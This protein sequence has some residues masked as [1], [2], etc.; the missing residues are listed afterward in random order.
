MRREF[1]KT[2]Q[3]EHLCMQSFKKIKFKYL[4]HLIGIGCGD[5]IWERNVARLGFPIA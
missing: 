5:K 2:K 4:K 1:R 3:K